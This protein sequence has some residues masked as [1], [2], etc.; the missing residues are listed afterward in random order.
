MGYADTGV[1]PK[2]ANMLIGP[3]YSY[4]LDKFNGSSVIS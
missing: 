3:I 1:L 4:V 2:T